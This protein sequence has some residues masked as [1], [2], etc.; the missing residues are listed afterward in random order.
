[1]RPAGGSGRSGGTAGR[2]TPRCSSQGF[3]PE[4]RAR[5]AISMAPAPSLVLAKAACRTLKPS[6]LSSPMSQRWAVKLKGR[7]S[8]VA[9]I[10]AA[11]VV[12]PAHWAWTCVAPNARARVAIQHALGRISTFLA[13]IRGLRASRTRLPRIRSSTWGRRASQAR[14]ARTPA[15]CSRGNS[16]ASAASAGARPWYKGPP[17]RRGRM[18][19]SVPASR[20]AANSRTTNASCRPQG[21]ETGM[22][23]SL[24]TPP[25]RRPRES[26]ARPC[27]RRCPHASRPA[28]FGSSCGSGSA[29]GRRSSR[30]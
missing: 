28:P 7:S 23:T 2:S 14:R 18:R 27:R 24:R 25:S 11:V 6:M 17:G 15:G 4:P 10:Q 1:M 26:R 16:S 3:L 30:C 29:A 8:R 12:V 19:I 13:R 20:R 21:A 22:R 9:A 5:S